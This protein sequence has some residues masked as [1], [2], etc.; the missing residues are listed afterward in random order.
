MSN[1]FIDIGIHMN[2]CYYRRITRLSLVAVTYDYESI[3]DNEVNG[4]CTWLSTII[5]TKPNYLGERIMEQVIAA[6]STVISDYLNSIYLIVSILQSA[7]WP[8][9]E[10]WTSRWILLPLVPLSIKIKVS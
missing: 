5:S 4:M 7:Y 10:N 6:R 8:F 3:S 9:Y 1:K 2:V